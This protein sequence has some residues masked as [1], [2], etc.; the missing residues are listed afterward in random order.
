MIEE[1]TKGMSFAE[2]GGCLIFECLQGIQIRDSRMADDD[3]VLMGTLQT[4]ASLSAP[5]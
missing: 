5:R 2:E 4:A 1:G 3:S